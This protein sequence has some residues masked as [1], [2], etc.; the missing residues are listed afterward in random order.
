[1]S[2]KLQAGILLACI[3]LFDFGWIFAFLITA[4]E[5]FHDDWR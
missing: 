3:L 2:E 5:W 4:H 1:M